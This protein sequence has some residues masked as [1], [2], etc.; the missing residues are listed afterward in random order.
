MSF[1]FPSIKREASVTCGNPDT[2]RC[3]QT[4]E[5]VQT[6]KS[7]PEVLEVEKP[8]PHSPLAPEERCLDRADPL[9]SFAGSHIRITLG[10]SY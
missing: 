9:A 1:P 7:V 8:S 2:G 3:K 6:W 10:G 4:H 5:D